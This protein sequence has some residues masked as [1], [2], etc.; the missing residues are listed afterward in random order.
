MK[1]APDW[2]HARYFKPSEVLNPYSMSADLLAM[3][4]DMRMLYT[5]PI[6]I[7]GSWRELKIGKERSSAHEVNS[8]GVWEGVDLR[9][10]NSRDRYAMK[11]AAYRAGFVR[12]GTYNLH[13]HLDIATDI[14]FAQYVEWIGISV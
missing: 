11:K 9:C 2:D 13:L 1:M 5:L 10:N 8:D 4:E 6:I 14:Q 7:T 3:L 12:I